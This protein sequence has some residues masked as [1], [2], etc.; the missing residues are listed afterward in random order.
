MA[1]GG[2]NEAFK[3]TALFP[4]TAGTF[5]LIYDGRGAVGMGTLPEL[6]KRLSGNATGRLVT[7]SG[8][9]KAANAYAPGIRGLRSVI[10]RRNTQPEIYGRWRCSYG[11]TH[12]MCLLSADR[13]CPASTSS[14]SCPW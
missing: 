6:P 5:P 2:K 8:E 3:R 1:S 11:S 4:R 7:H 12:S 10:C 9:F 14:S 13:W